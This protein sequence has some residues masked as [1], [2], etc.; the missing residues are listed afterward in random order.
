MPWTMAALVLGGLSLIGVPGTAGFISKW[1]LV[2]AALDEGAL[3]IFL[4]AVVVIGSLMAVVYIWRIIE[5]AWFAT[6]A[7]N[8]TA[9][10]TPGEA[11]TVM[12]LVT[13]GIALA[14]I[15]FGLLTGTQRELAERA[16]GALLG[17][18]P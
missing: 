17:S 5:A 16:A 18:L 13:W 2:T 11:P 7:D 3:G 8:S 4:I 15:A 1:Y 6:P 12:L 9:A 10:V 14:N